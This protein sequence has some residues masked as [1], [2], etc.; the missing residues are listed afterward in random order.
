MR[1]RTPRTGVG[2]LIQVSI[3]P[4][5]DATMVIEPGPVRVGPTG[6]PMIDDLVRLQPIPQRQPVLMS[7]A[8]T[9]G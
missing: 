7:G 2:E 4:V 1:N 5:Q 9:E 8:G 3:V 6:N